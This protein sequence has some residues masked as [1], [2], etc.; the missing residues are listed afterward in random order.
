MGL[1]TSRSLPKLRVLGGVL[2]L[3]LGACS[4][5]DEPTQFHDPYEAQNRKVHQFNLAVDRALV[6]PAS[7]AYGTGVPEVARQGISNF[8]SNAALPGKF[9]NSALQGDVEGA[10]QNFMRFLFNSTFGIF[11]LFDVAGEGGL[12]EKD[13]DFGETLAVWGVPE[14]AYFEL[15]FLGPSTERGAVGRV[16]DLFTNPLSQYL[17]DPASY[18]PPT[19]S[20]AARFGDRYTFSDSIDSIFYESADSYA[21]TRLFYLQSRRFALGDAAETNLID[22]YEDPYDELF[23]E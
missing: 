23:E 6:R 21:Q 13:T 11:G 4:V 19:A 12:V 14:G 17:D 1:Q 8:A 16:V 5:P 7:K 15:P 2:L 10:G 18:F 9:V 22:P 3:C 20:V